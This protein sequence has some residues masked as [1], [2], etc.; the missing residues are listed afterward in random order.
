VTF[1]AVGTFTNIAGTT[2]SLTTSTAGDFVLAE[3]R[4]GTNNTVTVTGLSS[5]NATWTQLGTS[6]IGSVNTDT[7]SVWLGKV[8]AASTATVTISWSGTTPALIRGDFQEFSSS[9]AGPIVLDKQGNLDG[10]GTNTWVSLTPAKS[11]ELYF[12]WALDSGS[13]VGGSTSGYVYQVDTQS[14]GVAYNLNCAGGVA[15]APVWGDST[16]VFGIMVL[17]AVQSSAGP[18]APL[19]TPPG[20]QSPMVLAV[21]PRFAIPP[22]PV[23]PP[24]PAPVPRPPGLQSP[25]SLTVPA[26]PATAA[27]PPAQPPAPAPSPVPPGLQ[28]PMV[29]AVPP[30]F[31][32]PPA[33]V[34][35]PAPAPV[36]RPPGLQSP[37]SLT[38][39]ARPATAA[40]PSPPSTAIPGP[41]PLLTPPGLQSPMSLTVPA[42]PAT[43]APPPPAI[44][45]VPGAAQ[46]HPPG[47]Q[48]PMSI[49]LPL[50]QPPQ[51]AP[52][53]GPPAP[54]PP[55]PSGVVPFAQG[56]PGGDRDPEIRVFRSLMPGEIPTSGSAL[57]KLQG[58]STGFAPAE[59]AED[60]AHTW[61]PPPE[62]AGPAGPGLL[63]KTK[64]AAADAGRAAYDLGRIFGTDP[65]IPPAQAICKAIR[66]LGRETLTC[67]LR[68]GHAGM[69]SDR[70]VRWG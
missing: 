24:A 58:R 25:M 1:S 2:P 37:M 59:R 14:N 70:G 41:A 11:G 15:T 61:E 42:R 29:L 55:I 60:T 50:Y 43:S 69:H 33:P 56:A 16:H 68:R 3:I 49:G 28:S 54:G 62:P 12:G 27:A 13:A 52:P 23:Q 36:P 44:T 34:Q 46:P 21:P 40:P 30:R 19:L 18:P 67:K 63:D 45:A 66:K 4:N 26:R 10:S 17:V 47:R 51:G 53:P 64:G 57:P 6:L 48:S 22:A 31:A 35:L 65:Y 32:I 7:A 38:V 9:V 20:L 8:T 5:S 39:P